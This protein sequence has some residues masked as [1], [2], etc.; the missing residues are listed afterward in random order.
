[1]AAPDGVSPETC[2]I[3]GKLRPSLL[4]LHPVELRSCCRRHLST[5]HMWGQYDCV[6]TCNLRNEKCDFA[7]GEKKMRMA[8]ISSV[9]Q[10][11]ISPF[12]RTTRFRR[13]LCLASCLV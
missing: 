5:A 7:S 8:V 13:A 9:W 2:E 1:M 11:F 3:P 12:R 10:A 4:P 6:D